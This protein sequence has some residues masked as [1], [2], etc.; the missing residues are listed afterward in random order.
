MNGRGGSGGRPN[1][2]RRCARG[3]SPEERAAVL[4]R[5]PL[6][7]LLLAALPPLALREELEGDLAE[8]LALSG[9]GRGW[10]WSQ[11]L[12]SAPSLLLYQ[13]T[14]DAAARKRWTLAG[15]TLVAGSV[16][17]AL[18]RF[19]AFDWSA[20]AVVAFGL[21]VLALTQLA[22]RDALHAAGLLA[23]SLILAGAILHVDGIAEAR[24]LDDD[25]AMYMIVAIWS[26]SGLT[27]APSVRTKACRAL[28]TG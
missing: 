9:R 19:H 27:G 2:G 1:R 5:D 13:A 17:T 10:M 20:V 23:G 25:T 26:L 21:A 24:G 12:R 8:E 22:S 28:H 18:G 16:L 15:T 7:R 6:S 3:G 4:P 11:L 14:R